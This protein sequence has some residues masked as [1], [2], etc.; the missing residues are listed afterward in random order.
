MINIMDGLWK[1]G[2]D[3]EREGGRLVGFYG[4]FCIYLC[5]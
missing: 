2:K 3:G 4:L 1:G 5:L